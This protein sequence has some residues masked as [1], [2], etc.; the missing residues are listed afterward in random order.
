MLGAIVIGGCFG[1]YVIYDSFMQYKA[2]G[3]IGKLEKQLRSKGVRLNQWDGFYPR[4]RV[5][6]LNR[7]TELQNTFEELSSDNYL[8]EE[9]MKFKSEFYELLNSMTEMT[10]KDINMILYKVIH[11]LMSGKTLQSDCLV[12][13]NLFSLLMKAKQQYTTKHE[14]TGDANDQDFHARN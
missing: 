5:E 6:F 10:E 3:Q 7:M 1:Y 14:R 12:A 9:M 11:L 8:F 4:K 2:L 13:N